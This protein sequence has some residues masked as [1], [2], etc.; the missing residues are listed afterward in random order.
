MLNT[1]N[2]A[3]VLEEGV[4]AHERLI[5]AREHHTSP[6]NLIKIGV[7]VSCKIHCLQLLYISHI[8]AKGLLV[9]KC[10][11]YTHTDLGRTS[12]GQM[13][14]SFGQTGRRGASDKSPTHAAAPRRPGAAASA[15]R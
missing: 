5:A 1:H 11:V 10:M 3:E 13:W 2:G 6:N 15:K 9:T 14:P 8:N 4:A 7:Y 12:L